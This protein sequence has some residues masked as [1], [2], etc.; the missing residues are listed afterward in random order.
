MYHIFLLSFVGG[1][2]YCY[3]ALDVVNIAAVNIGMHVSFQIIVFSK[4]MPKT[5]PLMEI[6]IAFSR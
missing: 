2:L 5:L 1:L 6:I 4:Y 3:H